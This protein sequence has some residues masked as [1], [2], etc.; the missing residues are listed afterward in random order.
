MKSNLSNVSSYSILSRLV[1]DK[2]KTRLNTVKSNEQYTT[3][4]TT[5]DEV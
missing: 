3:E 5:Y 4:D 1:Q 2:T